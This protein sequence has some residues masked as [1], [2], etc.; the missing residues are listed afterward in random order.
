MTQLQTFSNRL[1]YTRAERLSDAAVHGVALVA[2]LA[3]VP[4]LITLAVVWRGDT[5]SVV[6]VSIYGV[7]LIAM[8]LCSALYNGLASPAWGTVLQR[9]D[10]TAIYFKIA[11]TFTPFSLLSGG[12]G[13]WVL[14]GVWGAAFAGSGLR[15]FGG[16][17]WKWVTFGLYLAMGWIGTVLGWPLMSELSAP[18]VMLIV[19]GGLLYTA[20]TV[21]LIWD[22]LP[23]HNT[24]W[25]LF[26]MT[27]TA[28]FFSAIM[29]HLVQ[30]SGPRV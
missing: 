19:T 10:H 6:G 12:Q 5:A 25:H 27:A 24:I 18:V 4:V 17:R 28:V 11:G 22:Q 16:P 29:L 15:S 1:E 23:F 2:A 7:T 13:A 8:I 26:V 20:G 9:L 21:F 14:T 3:A 30:T